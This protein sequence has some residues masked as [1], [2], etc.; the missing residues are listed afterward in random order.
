AGPSLRP[1]R[2]LS[3]PSAV[4]RR[5]P[6]LSRRPPPAETYTLSLHDALPISAERRTRTLQRLPHTAPSTH[7]RLRTTPPK[8][9]GSSGRRAGRSALAS[10]ESA[11]RCARPPPRAPRPSSGHCR[12]ATRKTG[13]CVGAACVLSAP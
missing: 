2:P 7:V 5:A 1:S 10:S 13:T 11:K 4:T 8:H 3:P 9:G 6:P 12:A